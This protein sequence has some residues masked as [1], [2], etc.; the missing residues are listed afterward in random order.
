MLCDLSLAT[1]SSKAFFAMLRISNRP[2]MDRAREI[3]GTTFRIDCRKLPP[4]KGQ[5]RRKLVHSDMVNVV[6]MNSPE[7]IQL[8]LVKFREFTAAQGV[9]LLY[10]FK[11]RLPSIRVKYSRVI[12]DD[13]MVSQI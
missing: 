5:D 8:G 10:E 9:E 11:R 3:F 4:L 2:S 13:P 6:N 7:N 1:C 12:A